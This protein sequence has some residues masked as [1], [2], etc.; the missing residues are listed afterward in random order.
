MCAK[1]PTTFTVRQVK[2]DR[3]RNALFNTRKSATPNVGQFAMGETNR[4]NE[5]AKTRSGVPGGKS[6]RD[7]IINS[8]GDTIFCITGWV[9]ALGIGLL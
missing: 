8:I 5:N 2:G 9:S 4:T 7:S 3:F 6:N 1:I